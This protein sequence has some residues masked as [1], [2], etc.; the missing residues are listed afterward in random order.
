MSF[1]GLRHFLFEREHGRCFWCD[2]EV[3]LHWPQISTPDNGATMDHIIPKSQGG[4][5]NES[6]LVCACY[7]CNRTRRTMKAEEFAI[8]AREFRGDA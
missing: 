3:I 1:T 7:R 2:Q 4:Q 5:T 8:V 6:N